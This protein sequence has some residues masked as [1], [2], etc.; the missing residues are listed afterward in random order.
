MIIYWGACFCSAF[1]A[2]FG[3]KIK[4]KGN[5]WISVLASFPLILIA[6]LRYG[7]GTDYYSYISIV[8]TYRMG[9]DLNYEFLFESICKLITYLN[10][11]SQWL[12]AILAIIFCVSVFDQIFKD[13]PYVVLSV[14]L[15]LGTTIYF[16][17]LNAV[18]QFVGCAI[19]FYSIRFVEA[20]D[21]KKFLICMFFAVGMHLSCI[22]FAVTFYV[23]RIKVDVKKIVV[24][25]LAIRISLPVLVNLMH[26]VLSGTKYAMYLSLNESK[27]T[28]FFII[29]LAVF[30]A[31]ILFLDKNVTKNQIYYNY[32]FLM[33]AIALFHDVMPLVSRVMWLFWLP[34]I[35]LIPLL[36][37]G[38]KN[39]HLRML[40]IG[41]VV[42][43]YF[44]YA[45]YS[46]MISGSHDVYPY[47]SILSN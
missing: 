41:L 29:N 25:L 37:R 1:F 7:V 4:R 12:M 19:C 6:A 42:V 20:K 17:Y 40:F 15:L 22:V 28:F 2:E 21:L 34:Q 18:R 36:I 8:E 3:E 35:I 30:L 13:S 33:I 47:Q 11:N 24:S 43:L 44:I 23:A 16:T 14:F 32:Q 27:I 31:A 46:I 39:A 10:L 45:T 38:V 9:V 26:N 5:F